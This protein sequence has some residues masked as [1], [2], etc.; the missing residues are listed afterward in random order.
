MNSVWVDLP[1]DGTVASVIEITSVQIRTNIL[2]RFI[3]TCVMHYYGYPAYHR[4]IITAI[5]SD[6][7][8]YIQEHETRYE[9]LGKGGLYIVPFVSPFDSTDIKI[10]MKNL[11]TGCAAKIRDLTIDIYSP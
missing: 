5:N 2:Y 6:G 3:F 4:T 11:N 10:E 9:N 1:S 8:P 7:K